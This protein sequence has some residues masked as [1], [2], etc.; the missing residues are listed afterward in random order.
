MELSALIWLLVGLGLLVLGAEWL[1]GGAARLAAGAGVSPLII[2]LTVVAFGTSAPE[3]AV[4]VGSVLSGQADLAF[5]NVVGSNISNVLLILGASAVVTPLV[6]AVPLIRLEVPVMIGVSVLVLVL[7]LDGALGRLDGVLLVAG[8]LGY[9][10]FQVRQGRREARDVKQEF[11]REFGAPANRPWLDI[12]RVVAGSVLLVVGSGWLVEGAV[13]MARAL[14]VSELVI[15]LTIVAAGTSLPEL[16][17]SVLAAVR[18]ERDIAV[19]NVVGSNIFNLLLVL[20][21]CAAIAPGGVAVSPASLRFDLPVMIAVTLACLPIFASGHVIARWEGALFLSYYGAYLLYLGLDATGHDALPFF[22]MAM[23][24][25][26][27]PLTAI[28]LIVVGLRTWGG[29]VLRGL[30]E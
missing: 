5:G 2:G 24:A 27:L 18:G 13:A 26:A 16:A 21:V 4:S 17:T 10:L 29:S 14:G 22:S 28:T 3:L 19:G 9:C 20:G 30:R 8:A 1:V 7:A 15:G 6:V 12:G 23:V 25:F 11:D